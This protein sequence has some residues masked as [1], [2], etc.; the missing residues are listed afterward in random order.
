MV[1][2]S[3]RSSKRDLLT[4]LFIETFRVTGEA[5]E[6]ENTLA[7]QAGVTRAR[8]QILQTLVN[9]GHPLTVA[10]T[11]R[12]MGLSRQGVQRI[13]NELIDAKLLNT[14]SNPDHKRSPL[15]ITTPKGERLYQEIE[16]AHT[17]WTQHTSAEVSE[18]AL[19]ETLKTIKLVRKQ[20]PPI[21]E[22]N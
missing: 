2:S 5:M 7:K 3:T 10:Q 22:G 13:V 6:C 18:S 4:S 17:D 1:M 19:E 9:A 8:W 20:I 12:R 11:A 15:V 16:A 21:P 14:R